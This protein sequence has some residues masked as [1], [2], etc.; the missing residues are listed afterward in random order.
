M[1]QIYVIQKPM[2]EENYFNISQKKIM[3]K[4]EEPTFNGIIHRRIIIKP[5]FI[6]I[7]IQLKNLDG[8]PAKNN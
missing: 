3:Q 5:P 7:Q 2:Q 6:L 1:S 8:F 4:C